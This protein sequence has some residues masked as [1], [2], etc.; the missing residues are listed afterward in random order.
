MAPAEMR[1]FLQRRLEGRPTR[2]NFRTGHLTV[3]TLM[4]MR[5]VPHRIV[6][7][8]GLDDGAF[9]RKAPRDGD[10]LML[11]EPHLGE[12]DPRSED[13]QLLL[14]A[15][16]AAQDRLIVT[17][18]GNDERTN[19]LRPPAVPVGE[20]LDIVD[21]TAVTDGG[22]ARDR[23]VIRHPLQPFDPRNFTAGKVAGPQPWSF[24]SVALEGAQALSA[25]RHPPQPFLAGALPRRADEVVELAELVRFVEHPV[26]AFLRQRLGIGLSRPCD[27]TPLALSVELAWLGRR[28]C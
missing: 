4:P 19:A 13:R 1:A 3:C 7:L 27:G 6:C 20:L 5:S 16:L 18:T 17:Y 28:E 10:D 9:P 15:L 12:R 24:D 23:V 22:R 2:A 25:P 8:L 21:A 11:A 14:D 26:K